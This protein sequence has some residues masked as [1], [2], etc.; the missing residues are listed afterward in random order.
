MVKTNKENKENKMTKRDVI[1]ML[2][3]RT[4]IYRVSDY[5]RKVNSIT[6]K[7]YN[8]TQIKRS[9][10][11]MAHEGSIAYSVVELPNSQAITGVVIAA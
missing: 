4:K 7:A 6:G 9:M 1:K 8:A 2:M 10:Y 3:G 5:V 11:H